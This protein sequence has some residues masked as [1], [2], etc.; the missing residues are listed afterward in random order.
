MTKTQTVNKKWYTKMTLKYPDLDEVFE[1]I[2]KIS[3]FYHKDIF[4]IKS[5]NMFFRTVVDMIEKSL[6][7]IETSKWPNS[8]R[9]SK[10]IMCAPDLDSIGEPIFA[11]AFTYKRDPKEDDIIIIKFRL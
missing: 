3:T 10:I 9:S 8:I 2:L 6:K 1:Q 7:E 5:E 4:S 11:I